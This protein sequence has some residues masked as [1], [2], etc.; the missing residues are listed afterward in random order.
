MQHRVWAVEVNNLREARG[1]VADVGADAT[2]CVL[3]APKA[4]HRVLKVTGLTPVQANIIK[5]EML[6]RGGEAAVARGVVNRS[7]TETD[8]LLMG[9]R[10][11]FAGFLDK[12][13]LQPFGLA[14]LGDKVGRVLENLER[15]PRGLDC[16]GW[17]LPLGERTLVMGILNVTPDSFSD[18]GRYLDPED[19]LRRAREM[20]A[21][22]ADLIDLGGESTRPGAE[23]V[24]VDEELARVMAVLPRLVGELKVPVS[25]DTSKAAVARPA[26]EAGAHLVNDQWALA[27]NGMVELVADYRVPVV[28]M[29]NQRGT[30]Y[31]GLVGDIIGYFEERLEKAHAAGIAADKIIL[32]P[33]FGFG[34]TP[35]QN[36]AVL[37]YLPEFKS[38]GCPLLIGTSRK[39]TIGKVLDLPVG[40]RV[41]G[42]AATVAVS[43]ARGA[44]LVRVHDVSEMV[45]VVRMA[46]AIVRGV[47]SE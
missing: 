7:V 37:R 4:V 45:R 40:E 10:K 29:H 2:G 44:D 25:I 28:L 42:T 34:K 8:V 24:G 38:L 19:A 12:M 20:V 39:S 1:A 15:V 3:M 21:G 11:Q 26:L 43:I 35:A 27:D 9:T 23:P 16:R 30:E 36:L 6:A 33:G 22:G 32:D 14:A 41:E 13:R 47:L 5:Q 31:A 17:W 18:G 46:D